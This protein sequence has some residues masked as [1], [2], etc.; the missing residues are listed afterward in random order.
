MRRQPLT[1]EEKIAIKIGDILCDLRLDIELI[2]RY[3]AKSLPNIA[4]NRLIVI[5]ESAEYEKE[6]NND[7]FYY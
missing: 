6:D 7:N 1:E 5:A 2:G 4:Y 3:I